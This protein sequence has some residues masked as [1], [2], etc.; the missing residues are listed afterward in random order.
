MKSFYQRA[1]LALGR[2]T[3]LSAVAIATV[4]AILALPYVF[5]WAHVGSY[6][7]LVDETMKPDGVKFLYGDMVA[8]IMLIATIVIAIYSFIPNIKIISQSARF[9]HYAELDQSYMDLL[10][11]S[12]ADPDLRN[13][14]SDLKWP[15]NDEEK[16]K[17]YE[18]YAFM[19]W[20]FVET[21][22]DR[23]CDDEDLIAIWD[24]IIHLEYEIHGAWFRQEVLAS[25]VD[26][27]RSPKFCKQ[28]CVFIGR[29]CGAN[30]DSV[31]WTKKVAW[32]YPNDQ[33]FDIKL[34]YKKQTT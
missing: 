3:I 21:I 16:K 6:T 28:F 27:I 1:E 14:P 34:L 9:A 2:D 7:K 33:A 5:Y 22:R 20:N 32:D 13:P 24:P 8:A 25:H 23:C 15:C 17:K 19:V 31:D 18:I 26:K 4:L 30:E 29:K 12:L 10:K 11:L